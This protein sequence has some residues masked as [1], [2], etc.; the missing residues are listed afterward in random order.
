[1]LLQIKQSQ[2]GIQTTT[3]QIIIPYKKKKNKR[4]TEKEIS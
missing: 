4:S 1:M 2:N 3:Q